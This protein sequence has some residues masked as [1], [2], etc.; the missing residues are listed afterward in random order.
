METE[1]HERVGGGKGRVVGK[2]GRERV[3]GKGRCERVGKKGWGRG[4]GKA[5]RKKQNVPIFY[6]FCFICFFQMFW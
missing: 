6:S 1:G 5:N 3:G 2:G 4:H